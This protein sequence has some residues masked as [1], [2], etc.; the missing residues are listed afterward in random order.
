MP[1]IYEMY[2]D[3]YL[4]P[5][6]LQ[7][8]T[9]PVT[10]ESVLIDYFWNDKTQQ[11]EPAYVVK[12][13]GKQLPFILNKTQCFDIAGCAGSDDWQTWGGTNIKLKPIKARGRDT[14]QVL[15]AN[16]ESAPTAPPPSGAVEINEEIPHPDSEGNP[17][18]D[19]PAEDAKE[20]E[21]EQKPE[22]KP[23]EPTTKKAPA[24]KRTAKSKP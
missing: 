4:K 21:P 10:I 12:M 17:F 22:E 11:K 8:R 13:V 2:P 9:V 18:D 6:H 7:G 5:Y 16:G 14:I 24:K 1:S 19:Q 20:S 15:A 3:R 23:E